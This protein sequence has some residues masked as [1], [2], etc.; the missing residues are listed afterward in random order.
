[1]VQI[2]NFGEISFEEQL[3]A[4]HDAAV[5]TG[6]HGSDLLNAI[7]LPSRGALV[8]I[9]PQ[10]RGAQVCLTSNTACSNQAGTN[11][12]VLVDARSNHAC[13]GR[14]RRQQRVLHY[15]I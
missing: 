9:A 11:H 1:M 14:V 15:K 4:V 8:E 10:N 5:L 12:T 7:F 2:V 6:I 3:K 13:S